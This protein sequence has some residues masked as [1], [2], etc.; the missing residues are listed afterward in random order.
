MKLVHVPA[1]DVGGLGWISEFETVLCLCQAL[2][3]CLHNPVRLVVL[4]VVFLFLP[5]D[6]LLQFRVA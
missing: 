2:E 3:A 1:V 5:E 4:V 6:Q